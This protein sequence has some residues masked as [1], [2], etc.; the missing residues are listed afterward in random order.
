MTIHLS[1]SFLTALLLILLVSCSAQ[2]RGCIT[3][4]VDPA[5]D[6]FPD[7][8]NATKSKNWSVFYNSTYKIVRNLATGSSYLLY[9][10]GSQPPANELDMHDGVIE[11]PVSNVGVQ[12]TVSI[13]YLEQ[14]GKLDEI[15]IFLTDPMFISSPCFK[16]RVD[17]GLVL[18]SADF[19]VQTALVEK[20]KQTEEQDLATLLAGMVAFV[21][22]FSSVPFQYS[23]NVSAYTET[24]NAAIFEWVKFYSTFFNEEAMANQVV[25]AATDRFQCVAENAGRIETDSMTA[26]PVVLWAYYSDYCQGWDIAQ[27]PN[28]YCEFASSCSVE[29]LN[30]TKGSIE[31]CGG[32]TFMTT[33]EVI[34][35]G[36]DADYFFYNADNWNATYGLFGEQLKKGLKS[37]QN[38]QVYDYLG[39]GA[40]AWFEERYASYYDVL[41]D[42]C[43]VVGTTRALP[44]GRGWFRNT[45]TE[46]VGVAGVCKNGTNSILPYNF[47]CEPD[48]FTISAAG[49]SS[50]QTGASEAFSDSMVHGPILFASAAMACL[51]LVLG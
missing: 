27:C 14:I 21:S 22:P 48:E 8:V 50:G 43:S 3:G 2:D 32:F 18:V 38:N 31:A 45:A 44:P 15:V 5:V 30:S 20:S 10:C 37:V 39:A 1:P 7:K 40:N 4:D 19:D 49:G 35:L 25:A 23:V 26:K 33:E 34:E 36:K 29:I 42:F 6:Y 41:Q 28:Y 11:I 46:P 9:Q 12:E 16:K 17:T 13:P 24:T 51:L 47:A